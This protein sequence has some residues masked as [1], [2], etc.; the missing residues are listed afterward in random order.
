M[1]S[2]TITKRS[3]LTGRIAGTHQKLD[4]AARIVMNP[5]LKKGQYFPSAKEIIKFEGRKGPDG[6]KT[7]S[8]GMD[9]PSHFIDPN[10]PRKSELLML[11]KDHYHGLE[12]ALK[13]KDRVRSAFEAAW[14]AHYIVDGLT[15]AH[16]FPVEDTVNAMMGEKEFFTIFKKPFKGLIRGDTAR[17]FIKNNWRY[18]GVNGLMSRHIAFEYGV[19][20]LCGTTPMRRYK[21]E[22]TEKD[23]ENFNLEKEFLAFLK[24]IN[25]LDL[26]GRFAKEGWTSSMSKEIEKLLLPAIIWVVALAWL[27]AIPKKGKK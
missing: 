6:L 25:K 10:H 21:P 3:L 9:N 20:I 27:S 17:S 2:I 14:L 26:Y 22:I 8:P 5:L 11:I 19:A 24:E 23:L 7:K 18:W 12:E 1:F 15:P 13:S 4:Q 16:H